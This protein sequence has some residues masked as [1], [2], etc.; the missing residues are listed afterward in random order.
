HVDARA[1]IVGADSRDIDGTA[2]TLER[3]TLQL[4][5]RE[6][7][8]AADRSAVGKGAGEFKQLISEFARG[9]RAA[10]HGPIDD[11]LLRAEARP[12]DEAN[13]NALMRA[14]FDGL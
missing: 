13:G 12:L 7:D 6:L 8:A 10:D 4:G 9:A 14:G 5:A 2:R 3:R 11:K 1:G